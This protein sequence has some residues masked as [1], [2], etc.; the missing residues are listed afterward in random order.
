MTAL[1]LPERIDLAAVGALQD[2]LSQALAEGDLTLDASQ[3]S[4][5]GALGL[6]LLV[7]AAKTARAQDRKFSITPR[8]EAFDEAVSR[9]GA[10]LDDLEHREETTA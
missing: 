10:S 9:L 5:L 4:H 6:Q 1:D 8:S 2:A 7:S 3:V